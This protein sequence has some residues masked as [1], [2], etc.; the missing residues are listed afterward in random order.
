LREFKAVE[1]KRRGGG[2]W[3]LNDNSLFER[4]VAVA[5]NSYLTEKKLSET[6]SFQ[7]FPRRNALHPKNIFEDGALAVR[8]GATSWGLRECGFFQIIEDKI[9]FQRGH[10]DK[11][12]FLDEQFTH[13]N[14]KKPNEL[15]PADL[16][17]PSG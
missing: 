4:V 15:G 10:W 2:T 16:G 7:S 6:C 9:I 3:R 5:K 8:G 13:P 1:N 12:S 17:S 11:L 14:M